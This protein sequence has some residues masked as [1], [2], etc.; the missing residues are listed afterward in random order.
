[1]SILLDNWLF[2]LIIALCI[3]MHFFHGHGHGDGN[4]TM[5]G[6]GDEIRS[7]RQPYTNR[8]TGRRSRTRFRAEWSRRRQGL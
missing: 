7:R 5:N 2:L 1:M 8:R 4:G 3:G 6:A